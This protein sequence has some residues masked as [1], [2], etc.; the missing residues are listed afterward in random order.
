MLQVLKRLHADTKAVVY[1][2]VLKRMRRGYTREA[3]MELIAAA[4]DL[5]PDLSLS[6]DIIV[7]FC[8]ES[9]LVRVCFCLCVLSLSLALSLSLSL[10]LSQTHTFSPTIL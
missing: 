9:E 4:R 7:G 1:V 6:T 3:Y 5:I 8:G 2:Q 10:S